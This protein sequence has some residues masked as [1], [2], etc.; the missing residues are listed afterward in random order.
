MTTKNIDLSA[1][2]NIQES[3]YDNPYLFDGDEYSAVFLH[4]KVENHPRGGE[5]VFI[6]FHADQALDFFANAQIYCLALC[7]DLKTMRIQYCDSAY[8]AKEF[9]GYLG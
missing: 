3:Q 2:I 9:Y 6:C 4:R 7:V 8:S 1:I 5:S